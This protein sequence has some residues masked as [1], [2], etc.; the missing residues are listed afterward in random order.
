[1]LKICFYFTHV[2]THDVLLYVHCMLHA[3]AIL[4]SINIYRAEEERK[5]LQIKP[6]NN[7]IEEF[8]KH[9]VKRYS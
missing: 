9:R 1:M 2:K 6:G 8:F 5:Q 3:L 7:H 4:T